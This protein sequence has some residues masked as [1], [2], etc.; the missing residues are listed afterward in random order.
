MSTV[1]KLLHLDPLAPEPRG[2]GLAR[3]SLWQQFLT[4]PVA[5]VRYRAVDSNWHYA[6]LCGAV[7]TGYNP[8]RGEIYVAQNSALADWLADPE[9]DQRLYNEGDF[10]VNEALFAIHDYLHAWSTAWIQQNFPQLEYGYGKIDANNYQDHCFALLATEA[11]ATVG[12]DYWY[13][14]QFDLGASIDL[15]TE[16]ETLTSP[17]HRRHDDEYRRFAPNLEIDAPRFLVDMG[18][19]Y[20][21]GVFSGFDIA[22]VRRSPRVL[23][24]MQKELS[25]GELQRRYTREWLRH[26]GGLA[27]DPSVEELGA[28]FECETPWKMELLEGLSHALWRKVRHNDVQPQ[29]YCVGADETWR[30]PSDRPTDYRFTNVHRAS[31]R[32]RDHG[33][34]H[35]ELHRVSQ[36]ALGRVLPCDPDDRRAVSDALKQPNRHLARW[37]LERLPPVDLTREEGS[38]DLFVLQ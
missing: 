2:E 18:R 27:G 4:D 36:L 34:V 22:A 3:L 8:F 15:G 29:Q 13:L 21:T 25:Y 5:S 1:P 6:R 19:F 20:C 37:V 7:N 23:N 10:L 24:W 30:A 32:G 17:Y 35:S 14:A 38:V 33:H 28:T 9:G 31:G 26:L 12:L 11:V 16:T